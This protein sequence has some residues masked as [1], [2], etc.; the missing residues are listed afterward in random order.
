[1]NKLYV[2]LLGLFLLT[3]LPMEAKKKKET[4]QP[5]KKEEALAPSVRDC[6]ACSIRRTIGI[7]SSPTVCSLAPS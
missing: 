3:G 4:P 7:L 1:M 6:S 5:P 2:L